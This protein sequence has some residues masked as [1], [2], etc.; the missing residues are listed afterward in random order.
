MP[1][2][3]RRTLFGSSVGLAGLGLIG[4]AQAAGTAVAPARSEPDALRGSVK[5]GSVELPPLHQP[6]EAGGSP[7]NPLPPGRRLG[8]AVVGLGT[9]A[10]E[11][12]IPAFGE[13]RY[14]R[15]AAL[16]S[17]K[18]DKAHTVAAQYGVPAG[19][20][21]GYGDFDRIKNDPS[22]DIVYIVLPNSLH[23]EYTV[24]AARAGKHV[25]CEK[26]MAATVAEAEQMVA[27]CRDAG[28]QLMIAYRLQ[29]D[30]AH[31]TLIEIARSRRHGSIRMIEAINAQNDAPN[32][33]WRQIKAMAG[34]G[35]LPDVGLY[36]LNAF[37]YI[38]GE[39]PI[40]V[41][42]RLTQPKDD[43]RFREIEDIANFTLRFPSGI[44][45]VGTS[46]YSFHESRVLRVH[47]ETGTIGLDPA[48][49]YDNLALDIGRQEGKATA[50]EVRRFTPHSQFA[51]EMDAFA[52]SLHAR[53]RPRTP[54]EEGLQDMR[55]M[56]AIY[57]SAA[58]NGAPVGLPEVKELD[59]TRGPWPKE[60]GGF[61]PG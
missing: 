54:G 10:L 38:T 16:V 57:R 13:A 26:P 60:M 6:S 50:Q 9:L 49:G 2:I 4:N 42:G 29:Y 1:E 34:G 55:I 22:V 45:A 17:G 37:R 30:P 43:P 18:P 23:A 31:R 36:C 53:Q 58:Q 40:E 39:E 3:T 32:G 41:T 24:R 25:L 15:L 27:A 46:G 12:I 20:V 8:V 11:N 44:F 51:R 35:S 47:A 56:A 7:P 5:D 19:S 14:V 28:R 21:Y 48:F 33:Q 59:T 52:A 61:M